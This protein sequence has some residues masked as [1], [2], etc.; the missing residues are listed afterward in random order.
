V[1][2][3]S[4][5]V[6]C[7]A[8]FAAALVL[9]VPGASALAQAGP[10]SPAPAAGGATTPPAPPASPADTAATGAAPPQA[11]AAPSEPQRLE[12]LD[13]LS[14]CWRGSVNERLFR[15]HWLPLAGGMM[16]GAGQVVMQGRTIDYQ[17]L[18]MEA[19][20]DGVHYVIFGENG[21]H[22]DFR[23]ASIARDEANEATVFTFE[24]PGGAFPQRVVYRRATKGWLYAS[25]EGT[26]SGKERNVIYPMRRVDCETEEKIER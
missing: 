18:R 2:P 10:A 25:V 9:A 22:A 21:Q 6:R 4:P 24:R 12:A 13:W 17:Y 19:R 3:S 8:A 14:G 23:L 11:A 16:V 1:T 20:D 26:L 7:A 15:E 5:A